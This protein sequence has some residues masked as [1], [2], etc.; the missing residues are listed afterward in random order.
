MLGMHRSGTSLVARVLNLLGMD[1]GPEEDRLEPRPDNPLGYWEQRPIMELN[2]AILEALGGSWAHPPDMPAGWTRRPEI[3]ALADRARDVVASQFGAAERWAWKD[4]RASLTLPFWRE[5]VPGQRSI[6]C[7]RNPV[8]VAA[9]LL[10]RWPRGHT[11]ESALALWSRYSVAALDNTSDDDRLLVFY[12]DWFEDGER[13]LTSLARFAGC[14]LARAAGSVRQ[15]IDAFVDRDRRHHRSTAMDVAEASGLAVEGRALYLMVRAGHAVSSTL[16]P[17]EAERIERIEPGL[18]AAMERVAASVGHAVA[19]RELTV[20]LSTHQEEMA[21]LRTELDRALRAEREVDLSRKQ[22]AHRVAA[23]EQSLAWMEAA[24]RRE[25]AA[26]S[27]IERSVSWRLTKPLRLSKR[28]IHGTEATR[29]PP[30]DGQTAPGGGPGP[31]AEPA[32]LDF[33]LTRRVSGPARRRQPGALPRIVVPCSDWSVS[34]VNTSLEALG[35]QLIELGWEVEI[36]F[37]RDEAFVRDSAGGGAHMPG[38]PHRH[39]ERAEPGVPGMWEAL[40]TELEASA[41]CLLFMGYDFLGNSVAPALSENVGVVSWVQADDGD[42]YEQVYRLGRYCNVVVCVSDHIREKVTSLNPAIGERAA[43][44]H[45]SSVSRADVAGERAPPG[46]GLRIVYSGRLVQYQKRILDFVDLAAALEGAGVEYEISLIG[47]FS[48]QEHT[49]E[50]FEQLAGPYLE[51]GRIRL[52]GRMGREEILSELTRHD[53]FVLLSDFEGLPL[54]LTEAMARG[55]VP[56]VAESDS[57]IREV[58][59][60][61]NNGFVVRGRDYGAWARQLVEVWQDRSRLTALSDRA[62]ATVRERFAIEDLARQLDQV[63]R[64][65]ADEMASGE[66][67]RPPSL[68]GD[69]RRSPTGDVLPPPTLHRP[70]AATGAGLTSRRP[71]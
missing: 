36:L 29:D 43:V 54:S 37:T 17:D 68:H 53:F 1:L 3:Q 39:L 18:V 65:V 64:R 66:Y 63:F 13:Q 71:A 8:D 70:A 21:R 61:G 40:I 15:E 52:L 38:L 11:H 32:P 49:R 2:D 28:A 20:S 27:A 47:T 5:I 4:P 45:N 51:A 50:M 46:P 7:F 12:D 19:N 69:T 44:I 41:P 30:R 57:G 9:S 60:D 59:D 22:L 25:R 31:R 24:L 34:G 6:V 48:R 56:F 35:E 62:R 10:R 16:A 42:Y 14:D 58:I 23:G 55:C 33:N 26:R 67:R